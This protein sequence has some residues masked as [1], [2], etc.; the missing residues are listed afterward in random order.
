M[1]EPYC[2]PFEYSSHDHYTPQIYSASGVNLEHFNYFEFI[3][4]V[5]ASPYYIMN[6]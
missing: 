4:C 5:L 1:F 2:D 6:H 3:G